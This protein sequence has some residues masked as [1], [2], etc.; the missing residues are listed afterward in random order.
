MRMSRTAVVSVVA[1]ALVGLLAFGAYAV[2]DND[3]D[4]GF[5]PPWRGG[6]GWGGWHDGGWGPD[7]DQVTET[8]AELAADLASELGTSAE[9]VE[10][11]FRGVAETRLREAADQGRIDEADI[12]EILAAYDQGDLREIFRIV[13]SDSA[14]TTE[15]PESS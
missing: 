4:R 9:E 11:A 12:D 15:S 7:P 14:Q 1:L 10:G 5:G 8:R 6:H 2:S 13:K 3:G